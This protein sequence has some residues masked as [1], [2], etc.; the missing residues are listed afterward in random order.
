MSTHRN[1]HL[2]FVLTIDRIAHIQVLVNL[3]RAYVL[4]GSKCS[5][6]F[7]LLCF[8]SKTY[9]SL[10][11]NCSLIILCASVSVGDCKLHGL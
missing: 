2:Y 8:K 9:D 4:R 7:W 11:P 1:L 6:C 10:A 3:T 5:V